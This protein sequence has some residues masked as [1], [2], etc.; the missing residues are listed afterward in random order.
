[1]QAWICNNLEYWSN[2]AAPRSET[3]SAN[4]LNP[5]RTLRST[6]CGGDVGLAVESEFMKN[7][8]RPF[9]PVLGVIAFM[10]LAFTASF[11]ALRATF[12]PA[13]P[14]KVALT[15]QPIVQ[16]IHDYR[17]DHGSLPARLRDLV[18][19]YLTA[20][21]RDNSKDGWYWERALVNL[22]HR[23][24]RAHTHVAYYFE[25]PYW[26]SNG[27]YYFPESSLPRRLEIPGPVPK[28]AALGSGPNSN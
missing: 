24:E 8:F 6:Q 22:S 9:A 14:E 11:P 21:D 16:A 26:F 19:Q 10:L 23:T 20:V 1:M 27:W 4:P 25:N 7:R 13:N 12:G 18:P 3:V 28:K 15:G 5:E 2:P 17:S